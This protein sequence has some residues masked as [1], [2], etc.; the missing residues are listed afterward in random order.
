MPRAWPIPVTL[1]RHHIIITFAMLA[2]PGGRLSGG[3]LAGHKSGVVN[4]TSASR[5][6]AGV[7]F[8]YAAAEAV[9]QASNDWRRKSL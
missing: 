8:G 9:A 1:F 4:L 5:D 6:G 2:R 3:R 7:L